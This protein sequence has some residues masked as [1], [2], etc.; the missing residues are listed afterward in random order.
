[1]SEIEEC[2]EQCRAVQSELVELALGILSGR[3]RAVVLEHLESCPRCIAHLEQLSVVADT[4]LELAP[5]TEPPVGFE[6]R[7]IQHFQKSTARRR[8]RRIRRAAVLGA[9]A[10]VAI[11]FGFG[12]GS[13]TSSHS[14]SRAPSTSTA[15]MSAELSMHGTDLGEV[16]VS[17]GTSPWMYVTISTGSGTDWVMCEITLSGGRTD[18][19]GQFHLSD[20]Y[21][22]WGAPLPAPMDQLRSASVMTMK[23][24][25]L[26]EATL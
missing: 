10:A 18:M 4:M 11:A 5:E 7:L 15:A 9:A 2:P 6:L 25:V 3:E 21:G 26:A 12:I 20:G 24:T 22:S 14:G 1:V 23:G 16:F 13:L 17:P 8:P 19:I